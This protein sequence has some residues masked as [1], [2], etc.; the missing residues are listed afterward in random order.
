[1]RKSG[2]VPLETPS[3]NIFYWILAEAARTISTKFAG[4]GIHD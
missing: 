4:N 1:M 2:L 3:E